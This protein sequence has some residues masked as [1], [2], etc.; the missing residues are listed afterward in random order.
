MILANVIFPAPSAAYVASMFFPLAALLALATEF[1]V[2]AVFQRNVPSRLGLFMVVVSVNVLSWVVGFGLSFLL[3]SGLVPQ[4]VS[5]GDHDFPILTTGPS[6][7]MMAIASFFWACLLSFAIEYA[8]LW[9]FREKLHFRRLALCTAL[10]NLASYCVIAI[11]VA[12]Y[13]HFDLF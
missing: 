4:M 13:L 9:W 3:P 8:A 1:G 12:I 6:W 2:F 10:A 7:G 11:V 5:G